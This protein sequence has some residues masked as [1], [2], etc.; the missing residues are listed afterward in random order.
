MGVPMIFGVVLRGGNVILQW[1][2][3]ACFR[4]N[5]S[6]TLLEPLTSDSCT[7]EGRRG[8]LWRKRDFYD[9]EHVRSRQARRLIAPQG[10]RG[11]TVQ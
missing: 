6:P 7:Q 3:G 1:V 10:K 4:T 11:V 2:D 8:R 5:L 9:R